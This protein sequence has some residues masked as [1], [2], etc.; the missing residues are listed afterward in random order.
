MLNGMKVRM[1]SSQCAH[2]IRRATRT[3]K[4]N[5]HCA[6]CDDR[7]YL[8]SP[9]RSASIRVCVSCMTFPSMDELATMVAV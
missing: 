8:H 7:R 5:P 3:R 4:L 2:A 1:P 9:T 6:V